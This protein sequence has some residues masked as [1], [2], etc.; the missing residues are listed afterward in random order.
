MLA[1]PP[2]G[3]PCIQ[4]YTVSPES[5]D[6]FDARGFVALRGVLDSH[7]AR[8]LN[9]ALNDFTALSAHVARIQ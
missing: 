6:L 3:Q 9:S 7:W 4:L 5:K 1:N 2:H 8:T